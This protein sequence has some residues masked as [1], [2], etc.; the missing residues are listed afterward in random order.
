MP[1]LRD[2]LTEPKEFVITVT[3]AK[4]ATDSTGCQLVYSKKSPAALCIALPW[5]ACGTRPSRTVKLVERR[6]VFKFFGS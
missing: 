6:S 2:L 5:T 1:V 4:S 3:A